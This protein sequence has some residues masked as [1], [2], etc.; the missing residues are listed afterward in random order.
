MREVQKRLEVAAAQLGQME[1]TLLQ[2]AT[3]LTT[4]L[5]PRRE[6]AALFQELEADAA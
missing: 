1:S 5:R 2:D 3:R 6:L 4:L